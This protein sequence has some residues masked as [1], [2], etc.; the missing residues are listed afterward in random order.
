[1]LLTVITHSPEQFPFRKQIIQ[2]LHQ[3]TGKTAGIVAHIKDQLFR[4]VFQQCLN[5]LDGLCRTTLVKVLN[6]HQ[7]DVSVQHLK[8]SHRSFHLPALNS[9]CLVGT[10]AEDR[11]GN[12]GSFRSFYQVPDLR[13]RQRPDVRILYPDQQ[14]LDLNAGLGRGTLRN[15][16]DDQKSTGI[17]RILDG[18]AHA[19]IG[20]FRLLPVGF[21]FA[22]RDVIA[23]PVT[24]GFDHGIGCRICQFL[25][26][27]FPDKL[28]FNQRFQLL[29]F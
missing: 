16:I 12:G 28:F 4:A 25:R 18:H 24:G 22:G 9:N 27:R 15:H 14:V 26:I 7:T 1:M 6:G 23:P 17:L 5:G 8:G 2:Q 11:Q 10:L 13:C 3:F 29:Q 21:I 20:I 19:N